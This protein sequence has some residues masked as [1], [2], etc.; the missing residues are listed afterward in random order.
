M[1]TRLGKIPASFHQAIT[2]ARGELPSIFANGYSGDDH[3]A[4]AVA[5]QPAI[6]N[7]IALEPRRSHAHHLRKLAHGWSGA[8]RGGA[9]ALKLRC[10]SAPG[11][12]NSET[13]IS[14]HY[15]LHW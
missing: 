11:E 4:A 12:K 3:D 1:L 15:M 7:C 8:V 10:S 13:K 6:E 2:I 5:N 9:G 14:R